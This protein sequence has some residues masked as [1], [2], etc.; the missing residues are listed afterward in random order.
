MSARRV[1]IGCRLSEDN[2]SVDALAARQDRKTPEE[3]RFTM[4][5]DRAAAEADV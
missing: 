2:L 4:I 5:E 1:R 3:W